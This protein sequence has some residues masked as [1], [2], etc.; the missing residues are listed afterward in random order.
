MLVSPYSWLPGWTAKD[1]WLGGSNDKVCTC[2]VAFR[3]MPVTHMVKH[4]LPGTVT[5]SA[6]VFTQRFAGRQPSAQRPLGT[7]WLTCFT[8]AA[9][10]A[11]TKRVCFVLLRSSFPAGGQ[12]SAQRSC[13]V[14]AHEG[15]RLR[16]RVPRGHT[17][18]DQRAC[19]QVPVGMLTRVR[20]E[21]HSKVSACLACERTVA[22]TFVRCQRLGMSK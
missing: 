19:T 16:A 10:P 18:L 3:A 6:Y 4:L 7:H 14:T 11:M 20:L 5:G 22:W 17:L 2:S 13:P 9:K 21:T 1:K 12:P 8:L 15:Q